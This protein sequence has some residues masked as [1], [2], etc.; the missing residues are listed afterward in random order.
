MDKDHPAQDS[1]N[2]LLDEVEQLIWS[3]LD[4]RISDSDAERLEALIKSDQQVRQRYLECVQMHTDLFSQFGNVPAANP[5]EPTAAEKPRSPVLGSLG[6]L[7]R[8][9]ENGPPVT[10]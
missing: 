2:Q 10:D 3:L 9:I 7:T 6:D 4:D 1:C 8:K 5:E